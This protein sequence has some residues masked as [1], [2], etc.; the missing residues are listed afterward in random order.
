LFDTTGHWNSFLMN[1]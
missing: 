1:C